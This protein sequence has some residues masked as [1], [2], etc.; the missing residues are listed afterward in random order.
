MIYP[1][2]QYLH[3]SKCRKILVKCANYKLPTPIIDNKKYKIS[4]FPNGSYM[5]DKGEDLPHGSFCKKCFTYEILN[6]S[7]RKNQKV[8]VIQQNCDNLIHVLKGTIQDCE[9]MR[10]K[11]IFEIRGWK[12]SGR[13]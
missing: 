2:S 6:R 5:I 9:K 8:K 3:C 7:I 1:L 12:R 13:K 10:D 11:K 4:K